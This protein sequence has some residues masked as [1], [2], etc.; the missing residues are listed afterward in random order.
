[1]ELSRMMEMTTASVAG[2][3]LVYSV[4]KKVLNLILFMLISTYSTD[5]E[6]QNMKE[7]REPEY[8]SVE[9]EV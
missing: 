7:K 9:N 5:P 4:L 8:T 6:I 2:M 1:I 3:L